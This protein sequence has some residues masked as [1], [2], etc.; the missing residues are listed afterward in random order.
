MRSDVKADTD[1]ES[2]SASSSDVRPATKQT[3]A[4]KLIVHLKLV[5]VISTHFF[6]LAPV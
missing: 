3:V 1:P 2:I 5:L 6:S 4:G